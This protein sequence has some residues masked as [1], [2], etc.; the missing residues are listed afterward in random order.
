MCVRGGGHCVP[1]A[2][3]V[4]LIMDDSLSCHVDGGDLTPYIKRLLCVLRMGGTELIVRTPCVTS[5]WGTQYIL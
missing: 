3:T 5:G 2:G 4:Y 1:L